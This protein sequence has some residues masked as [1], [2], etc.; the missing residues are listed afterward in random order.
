MAEFRKERLKN[1]VNVLFERRNLPITSV[2]IATKAGAAHETAD[3]KGIAHFA[4]HMP[5][6][7]TH[8]RNTQELSSAIEKVGG[9]LNAFTSD[10]I[11]A[12]WCKIPSKHFSEGFEIIS[13]LV[14]NPKFDGKDIEKE[15]NVI[16]SEISRCH[17]DSPHYLF[18]KTKELLYGA[19]FGM[20]VLGS[21]K[22]VSGIKRGDFLKWHGF[23]C[24]SNL[25]ISVVGSVS[26]DD[27]KN[28]AKCFDKTKAHLELP[29]PVISRKS[30][31]FMEKRHGLDQSH[32]TLGMHMPTLRDEKRYSSEIFNAILGEGMSSKLFREVREKRG[33]AYAVKSF[34]EQER[35]YGHTI[36]YAGIEKKNVKKVK[37][38][39]LK[40]IKSVGKT[41][42]RELDDAKEQKI[43]N[44][45]LELESCD[46]TAVSLA[47]QEMTTKAEDF[48]NYPEKISQVKLEDVRALAKIKQY[49]L[50]VLVPK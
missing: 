5:F 44:W 25:S 32:F 27:V 19:P 15:K 14:Q 11:T 8:T 45:E 21:K 48:Y 16:L 17:D 6:K 29:K 46:R 10:E 36:V 40:E 23:Y 20:P 24:P 37:D 30:G 18:D 47:I 4:E 3:K 42:A 22:T 50:A 2:L 28:A 26:F 35:S 49:S 7:A 43:G 13:D 34:L 12:F 41:T 9:I 39:V 1:G 38:I 33:L 31:N